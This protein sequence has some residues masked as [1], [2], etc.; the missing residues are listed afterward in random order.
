MNAS[1]FA[2]LALASALV[3]SL[4]AFAWASDE[5]ARAEDRIG[6]A[7]SRF[8]RALERGA[9]A[10]AAGVERGVQ[11]AGHGARVGAAAAARGVERA[12]AAA[13]R[14]AEGVARKLERATSPN[15]PPGSERT[16]QPGAR[17]LPGR[18]GHGEA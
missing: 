16:T 8:E 4:H 5:P 10:A 1:R 9:R 7:I 6:A 11:A 14:A 18:P 17:P 12:A 3:A 13:A 2:T 15:S